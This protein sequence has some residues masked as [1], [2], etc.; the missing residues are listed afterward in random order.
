MRLSLNLGG[1]MHSSI[2]SGETNQPLYN[3][4][5][6][7]LTVAVALFVPGSSLAGA[8]SIQIVP[9]SSGAGVVTGGTVYIAILLPDSIPPDQV[10]V[11]LNG[12][13]I[14]DRFRVD[15]ITGQFRGLVSGLNLGENHLG[16]RSPD[17][18]AR[19]FL[20]NHPITRPL[21]ARPHEE[22]FG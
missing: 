19:I 15:P 13:V 21:P 1:H 18:R 20:I 11:R 5:S 7:W 6:L 16:V 10:E 9:L 8:P 2:W 22:P 3:R 12:A 4:L 17:A 14:T